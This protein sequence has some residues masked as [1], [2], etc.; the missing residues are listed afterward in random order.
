[1]YVSQRYAR[2]I[3]NK[4]INKLQKSILNINKQPN[5]IALVRP[6]NRSLGQAV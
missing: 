1:V 6:K 4:T 2:G 5:L 3:V